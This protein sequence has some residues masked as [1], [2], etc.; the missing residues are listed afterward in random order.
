VDLKSSIKNLPASTGIYQFF[1][2]EDNLLYVGKAA[3]LRKR[4]AS[5]F[6]NKN[7]GPK[8]NLLV[9]KITRIEYIKVFSEFEALLL[10]SKII[11]D[12]QPFFNAIAK[13][14]KSPLYIKIEGK[15]IPLVLTTRGGFKKRGQF[16]KG[17]FPSAKT[18]RDVLKMIRKIFPYCHHKNP[19]KPCLFV[20]LGLCSYPYASPNSQKKYLKN[21]NRIKK[22]LSGKSRTLI[23]DLKREM[24]LL[25]KSQK[26]EEA[27]EIKKQIQKLE[28][29]T[30][31]YHAP[32]EFLQ[33]PTLV[34]DLTLV[35]LKNLQQVLGL[36]KLPKRIECYDI[37]NISGKYATGSM[38][39]FENGQPARNQYRKFKIKLTSKPNDYKMMQEVLTRRFKNNWPVA[40]LIIIDG[41]R[42]QLNTALRVVLK[43]KIRS[44]VISLSKR[45]EQI[46]TSENTLPVSLSKESPARQLVQNLRDEAHRFA[47]TYHRLLRSKQL[48][49]R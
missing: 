38:V 43:F 31:T 13:D 35:K 7:L 18:T 21:I 29:I 12:N 1:D 39:V 17:P 33:I 14:D 28:Y 22:L 19:K 10:E 23:R 49:A 27:N 4:V 20:H 32:E 40:D 47:I 16:L 8:T 11:K 24:A 41:G 48:T 46:Y 5:Y 42:G 25:A 26:F 9:K 6:Q 3:S 30:T 15:E 44:R 45:L 36:E 37:S 34:D 2:I